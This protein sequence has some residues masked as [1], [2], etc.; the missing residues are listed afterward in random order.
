MAIN[1]A[2]ALKTGR[3]GDIAKLK[4]VW[5]FD[6]IWAADKRNAVSFRLTV[7]RH[8]N[9]EYQKLKMWVGTIWQSVKP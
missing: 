2:L 4:F 8:V 1:D 5:G 9:A 3:R 6:R 7:R